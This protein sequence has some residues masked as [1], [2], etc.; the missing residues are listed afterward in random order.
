MANDK[1]RMRHIYNAIQAADAA[2]KEEGKRDA[3]KQ[4]MGSTA[5]MAWM[6]EDKVYV[7]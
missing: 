1:S 2:I 7:G 4:G 5:V 3:E 6:V